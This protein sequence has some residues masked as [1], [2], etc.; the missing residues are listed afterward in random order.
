MHGGAE[1]HDVGKMGPAAPIL[2]KPG[3]L[4]ADVQWFIQR[5]SEVEERKERIIAPP[6]RDMHP[7]APID[8]SPRG[9]MRTGGVT[10]GKLPLGEEPSGAE[11]R[12]QPQRH[13]P[14]RIPCR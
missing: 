10:L 5:H 2:D 14:F 13:G 3:A 7:G 11:L 12:G 8:R 4:D 1:L 9:C 6:V